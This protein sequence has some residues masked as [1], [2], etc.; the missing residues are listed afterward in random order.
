MT[1][2]DDDRL[3]SLLAHAADAFEVPASG[4]ED[5]L[6]RASGPAR[7]GGPD[8]TADGTAG[9]GDGPAEPFRD[10]RARPCRW[11]SP[12]ATASSRPPPA[13]PW[14]SWSPAPS[15]R[16]CVVGTDPDLGAAAGQPHAAPSGAP[17]GAVTTT[18]PHGLVAPC[19]ATTRRLPRRRAPRPDLL[20]STTGRDGGHHTD[21]A[22]PAGRRRRPARQ[23]SADRHTR[24]RRRPRRPDEDHD[25]ADRAGCRQRRLRRVTRRPSPAPEPGRA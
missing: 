25:E 8:G 13:S 15:G 5:I 1:M 23:D 14:R 18:V 11:R 16:S 12:V 3:A 6:T 9:A 4:V 7:D 22:L 24:P 2:L 21:R 19:S 20:R 17:A 10:G